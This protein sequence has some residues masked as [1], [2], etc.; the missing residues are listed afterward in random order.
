MI[1]TT[2]LLEL[3]ESWRAYALRSNDTREVRAYR[4]CAQELEDTLH[5]RRTDTSIEDDDNAKP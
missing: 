3:A 4:R 1:T 2:E 5:G